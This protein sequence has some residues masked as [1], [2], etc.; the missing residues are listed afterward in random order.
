M[1]GSR[2]EG[3][4]AERRYRMQQIQRRLGKG[5]TPAEI[6]RAL[7][8]KLR[9]INNDIL[10]LDEEMTQLAKQT[11]MAHLTSQLRRLEEIYRTSWDAYQLSLGDVVVTTIR[12]DEM[13]EKVDKKTGQ[14]TQVPKNPKSTLTRKKSAGDPRFLERASW[15]WQKYCELFG[16]LEKQSS[17]GQNQTGT[18]EDGIKQH[19]IGMVIYMPTNGRDMH[20]QQ[21]RMKM[22]EPP[23]EEKG[24]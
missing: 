3:I 24:K 6:A 2:R 10:L 12:S 23:A 21:N 20:L 1:A 4:T 5:Q 7:E 18:G 16:L 17:I 15:A 22:P 11:S 13:E 19:E 14:K 8:V 9:V